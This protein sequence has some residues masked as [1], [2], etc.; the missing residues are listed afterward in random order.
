M[1]GAAVLSTRA[2]MR[3]GAGYTRLSIPGLATDRSAPIEAVQV[4]LDRDWSAQVLADEARFGALVV[5]P[6]LG[7]SEATA[8]QVQRLAA[9]ATCPIVF[10]AD[11]LSALGH[12]TGLRPDIVLTPHDGEFERLCGHRPDVDRFSA[13][14][15]LASSSGATVLLKGP[16]T[17]V[18]SPDGEALAVTAGDARLATAGTGDVLAGIIG[19]LM[20]AGLSPQ[21]AAAAGAHWHGR[22]ARLGPS[23]GLVAGDLPDLLP[24]ARRPREI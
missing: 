12:P 10:D 4:P 1:T 17:I 19:A 13:A 3:A 14:R 6:G 8:K 15:Q 23:V 5:G 21:K 2:A 24:L 18:A 9:E 7:R 16:T 11:A 20:A 22:A